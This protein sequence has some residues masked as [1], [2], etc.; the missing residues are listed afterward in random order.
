MTGDEPA[1][2]HGSPVPP[3]EEEL[4]VSRAVFDT[5]V[6][7][8]ATVTE[9]R[10]EA[11]PALRPVAGGRHEARERAVHLLYECEIKGL[12]AE[13][14]LGAQVLAAEPYTEALVRGVSDRK[15]EID[16]VIAGLARGWTIQRMP[17]L[18]VVV[19]RV[20]CFE[21]AHRPEIPRGVVLAEAVDLAGRY[22]TDDSSRF[23]NGLLSAA[24]DC[25]RT[26]ADGSHP[27][28]P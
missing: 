10:V 22:G 19:M 28:S 27:G 1:A 13:A 14:V 23:V 26:P 17:R 20:A 3:K 15:D 4:P 8:D 9:N 21:L 16:E 18:D 6:D 5:V 2:P 12:S 25:L 24:A 11:P 7:A